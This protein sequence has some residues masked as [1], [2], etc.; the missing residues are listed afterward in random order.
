LFVVVAVAVATGSVRSMSI[1]AVSVPKVTVE[2]L[3]A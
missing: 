2:L 3:P 1:P